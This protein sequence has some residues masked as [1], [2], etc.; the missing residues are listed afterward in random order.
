MEVHETHTVQVVITWQ[1]D[2]I[3][4]HLTKRTGTYL[5]CSNVVQHSATQHPAQLSDLSACLGYSL[6]A[7]QLYMTSSQSHY[8]LSW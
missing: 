8:S 6:S 7:C 1:H 5:R 2:N 3:L 4:L